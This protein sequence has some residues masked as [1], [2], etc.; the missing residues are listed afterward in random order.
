MTYKL[1]IDDERF[2]PNDGSVWVIVRSSQEAIDYV[3]GFGIP[4][5]IS[6]D[7]DLGGDD[8]SIKFIWWLIDCYIEGTITSFPINYYIHSQNPIGAENIRGL[9]SSFIASEVK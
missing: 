2:P 1:F 9:L 6:Y 4:D 8:T 7:H 3:Q 5:F